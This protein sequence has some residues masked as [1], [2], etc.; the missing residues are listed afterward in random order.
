M[1]GYKKRALQI[2]EQTKIGFIRENDVNGSKIPN[3]YQKYIQ[4]IDDFFIKN[5]ILHNTYDIITPA[6]ML[7]DL[8]H[9]NIFLREKIKEKK[10]NE[11][12]IE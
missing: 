2:Y 3:I 10:E 4:G 11:I 6:R 5:M 8:L 7:S 12:T 9:K 1:S